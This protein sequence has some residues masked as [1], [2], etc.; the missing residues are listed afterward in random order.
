[1]QQ[2]ALTAARLAVKQQ[3]GNLVPLLEQP[4]PLLHFPHQR[5]AAG[6]HLR[7]G[8]AGRVLCG[9]V[10]L[11]HNFVVQRGCLVQRRDTQFLRQLV[12]QP[13]I[14]VCRLVIP[15]L[16]LIKFHQKHNHL[17]VQPIPVQVFK[18]QPL[19]PSKIARRPGLRRAIG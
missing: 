14:E 12:L 6:G 2:I 4:I 10:P 13:L 17:L 3:R 7:A 1:M 18:T 19:G 15:P 9:A 8:A 11:V 5:G 16:L